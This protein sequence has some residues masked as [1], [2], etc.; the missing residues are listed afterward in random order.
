MNTYTL[1]ARHKGKTIS[2]GF[3]SKKFYESGMHKA[4]KIYEVFEGL[5][6][7]PYP[8]GEYVEIKKERKTRGF[9]II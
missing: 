2:R 7:T 6:I 3:N 1:T 4:G 8:Y 9:P 5:G